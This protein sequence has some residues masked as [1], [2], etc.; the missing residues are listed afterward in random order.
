ME[1]LTSERKQS[2]A[3]IAVLEAENKA[4]KKSKETSGGKSRDSTYTYNPASFSAPN[5]DEHVK[6]VKKR[7][8]SLASNTEYQQ[9]L[10]KYGA[11][12]RM[13]VNCG[14]TDLKS[15]PCGCGKKGEE[16][17]DPKVRDMCVAF[18]KYRKVQ[19]AAQKRVR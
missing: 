18:K 5:K 14:R 1:T 17:S 16:S 3:R 9:I 7:Y 2:T 10:D 19:V 8:P 6:L 15:I 12:Y 4:L 11:F 13:C